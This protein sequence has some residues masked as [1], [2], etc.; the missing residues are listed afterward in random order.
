[1]RKLNSVLG[2]NPGG[3]QA[4]LG[5]DGRIPW[6]RPGFF[7]RQSDARFRP[8]LG[9][10]RR[11]VHPYLDD[12]LY[13]EMPH[14]TM[15]FDYDA[16]RTVKSVLTRTQGGTSLV[17]YLD[18]RDDVIITEVFDGA[19]GGLAISVE[20]VRKLYQYLVTP[21]PVGDHIGW[22]CPDL[23]PY[24]YLVELIDVK[25]GSQD[26][27]HIEEL[28]D[29]EPYMLAEPLQIIMKTIGV[30]KPPAGSLVFLGH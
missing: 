4:F 30:A 14:K 7:A 24:F 23:S 21:L 10:G 6:T 20:F 22:H 16:L 12:I 5:L 1:M 28:G 15:G 11:L 26:T 13:P 9:G 19:S 29:H 18:N 8:D 25:L 2:V 27:Y 3:F 17:Q